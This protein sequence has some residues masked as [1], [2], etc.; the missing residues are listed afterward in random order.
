MGISYTV[1]LPFVYYAITILRMA[2]FV[3]T[4]FG[5]QAQV[6]RRIKGDSVRKSKTFKS[7]REA[8]IWAREFEVE[9]SSGTDSDDTLAQVFRRYSLERSVGKK[10]ERWEVIRLEKFA[11]EPVNGIP[12]GEYRIG[13]ITTADLVAW[14]DG[15]LKEVKPASV[16]REMNLLKHV[17][18]TATDEWGLIRTNPMAKVKRP[19][20]GKRR[21]RRVYQD[22]IERISA[23]LDLD[24]QPWVTPKQITGAAFLFA[25]ETAMR[26]GEILAITNRHVHE[27][28]VHLPET[29]SDHARDV[30]MT[31]RAVEILTLVRGDRTELEQRPFDVTPQKRDSS[32][33]AA[34][35]AAKV[36]G[37]TFH[38]TR[39]EGITRLAKRL[40]VLDLSRVTG[41]KNL[42]ELLTYYEASGKE[43]AERLNSS[44]SKDEMR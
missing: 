33:R 43:L 28:V 39:H 37:L 41:H 12:F 42:N 18:S 8:Q 29:K 19:P 26:S 34:M 4:K 27:N 7:K 44:T 3:K 15:R 1:L 6:A 10:G 32:F 40:D 13:D 38:D 25:I 17:F 22:E 14:R 35:K 24:S 21:T 31:D 20:G 36:E 16:K 23:A 30:P 11:R 2:T 9:I 5:W